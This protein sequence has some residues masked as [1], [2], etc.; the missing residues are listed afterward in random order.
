MRQALTNQS[1]LFQSKLIY[2]NFLCDFYPGVDHVKKIPQ[3][4]TELWLAK[5]KLEGPI[6]AAVRKIF[7]RTLENLLSPLY[8][9]FNIQFLFPKRLRVDVV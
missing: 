9:L 8:C 3:R 5:K 2:S 6:I 4:R 1:A 7:F